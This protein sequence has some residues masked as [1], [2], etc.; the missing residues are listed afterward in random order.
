VA[1]QVARQSWRAG[2]IQALR[3]AFR[4]L[5]LPAAFVYEALEQGPGRMTSFELAQGTDM[6]RSTVYEALQ[7]L[8][9]F[10]LVQQRSGRWSIVAAT[11]LVVL[12]ESLGCA[13]EITDRLR[14]HRLERDAFRR[15]MHVVTYLET[16]V[17]DEFYDPVIAETESALDILE[18]ILGAR[19]LA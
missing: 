5:G 1:A 13:A 18:R 15:V 2:K 11:S 7:I 6:A 8:A 10:K 14:R 16:A 12:S 3:P 19:R 4:E 9:A 17:G